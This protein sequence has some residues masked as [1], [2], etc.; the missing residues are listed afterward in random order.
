[1]LK[2]TGSRPAG[3]EWIYDAEQAQRDFAQVQRDPAWIQPGE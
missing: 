2:V 3:I 1:V